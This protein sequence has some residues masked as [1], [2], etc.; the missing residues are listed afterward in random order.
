ML[1]RDSCYEHSRPLARSAI[2]LTT[3]VDMRRLSPEPSREVPA[4]IPREVRVC[5]HSVEAF[6]CCSVK[7]PLAD[8][9]RT[10]E[11]N[12]AVRAYFVPVMTTSMTAPTSHAMPVA[13]PNAMRSCW[14]MRD[15]RSHAGLRMKLTAVSLRAIPDVAP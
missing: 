11:W 1:H 13:R 7:Q 6:E 2:R 5:C 15:G 8:P 3:Y 10:E 14:E 4:S 9:I 12:R